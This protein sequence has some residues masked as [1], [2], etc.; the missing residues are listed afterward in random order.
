MGHS[1]AICAYLSIDENLWSAAA[2]PPPLQS[3]LRGWRIGVLKAAEPPPKSR[4]QLSLKKK[5]AATR[6]PF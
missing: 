3:N 2:L 4:P 1:D 5:G 6:R